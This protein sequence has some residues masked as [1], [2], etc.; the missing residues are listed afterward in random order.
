MTGLGPNLLQTQTLWLSQQLLFHCPI[1][2]LRYPFDFILIHTKFGFLS[3]GGI[4]TQQAPEWLLYGINASAIQRFL[5]DYSFFGGRL[6][7]FF[8][9]FLFPFH[10]TYLKDILTLL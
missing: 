4:L 9:S 10:C 1:F 6:G 7:V 3:A 8:F 5:Q 2:M